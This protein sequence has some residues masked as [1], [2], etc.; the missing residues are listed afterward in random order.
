MSEYDAETLLK[1]EMA[2]TLEDEGR[3]LEAATVYREMAAK[4]DGMAQCNLGTLLTGLGGEHTGEGMVWYGRAVRAGNESAA[5]CLAMEY[6]LRG[7]R[8]RYLNWVRVAARL[9]DHDAQT[10][11]AEIERR[12]RAGL[13][14]AMLIMVCVERYDVII[15]LSR[16]R[17]GTLSGE[18]VRTWAEG[19]Q[20]REICMR[21]APDG[22]ASLASVL[23]ELANEDR[24]LTH[25]RATELIFRL[26]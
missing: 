19:V 10:I 16:F 4:G 3:L 12:C 22:G 24:T 23:A 5:W 6:R 17:K 21:L 15:I 14:W 13:D 20:R 18:D 8:R 9:G 1:F 26:E 2:E 7:D 25:Q 11:L